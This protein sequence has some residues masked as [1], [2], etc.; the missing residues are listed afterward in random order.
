M[1]ADERAP[2]GAEIRPVRA[3]LAVYLS[4]LA[5]LAAGLL[6]SV[7][8]ARRLPP[9]DYGL[10]NAVTSG[11]VNY[12]V[13]PSTVVTYWLHR[14]VA[15]GYDALRTGVAAAAALGLAASLAYAAVMRA[16]SEDLGQPFAVV[17]LGA[18]IV[19]A[20]YVYLALESALMAYRPERA[21]AAY[22]LQRCAQ[23]SLLLLLL[24]A[25]GLG[26]G[27]A[28]AAVAA[29]FAAASA[30]MAAS[31]RARLAAGRL[32]AGYVRTWLS[33]GWLPAYA[34]AAGMVHSLDVLVVLYATGSAE[35]VAYFFA[36]DALAAVVG[37]AAA[38]VRPAGAK[39]L[40]GG[41]VEDVVPMA[42]LALLLT[43][44]A[45][46]YLV[47]YG[48]PLLSLMNPLYT[49]SRAVLW[50][51][52]ASYALYP[53]AGFVSSLISGLE[54]RDFEE[55]GSAALLRTALFRLPTAQLAVNLA[56]LAALYAMASAGAGGG[57]LGPA[58][59]W[60]LARLLRSAAQAAALTLLLGRV[61]GGAEAPYRAVCLSAAKY[62]L[63]AAAS[64]ALARLLL[65]PRVEERAADQVAALLP[66]AA[67]ALSAYALL[68][69][70]FDGYARALLLRSYSAFLSA[71]LSRC[72]PR[73][74]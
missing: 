17:A 12:F 33:R 16:V 45:V 71:L 38:A 68:A 19:L 4:R 44:P 59:A 55:G 74:R 48:D 24:K 36:A 8:V 46:A 31:E 32:E 1:E 42:R 65:P 6:S 63:M 52:A 50:L 15:R 10:W 39:L 28:L 41:R 35:A 51:L 7:V 73:R 18:P 43:A 67:V 70:A 22:V 61:R 25:L 34:S 9:G 23:A 2:S 14:Y 60:G 27:A 29:S 26:V 3:G 56:Y 49:E 72:R 21:A 11:Y 40:G 30:L 64:A 57:P 5:A 13:V 37:R 54:R 20:M 58:V 62:A 53:Y 69:L 47:A 66:P